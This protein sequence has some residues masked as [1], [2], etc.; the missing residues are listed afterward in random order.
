MGTDK[1]KESIIEGR[2]ITTTKKTNKTIKTPLEAFHN[3]T[4]TRHVSDT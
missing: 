1:L 2:I 3:K 4:R